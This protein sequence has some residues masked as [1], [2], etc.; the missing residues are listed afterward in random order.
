MFTNELL[1][2]VRKTTMCMT[3]TVLPMPNFQKEFKTECDVG[4]GELE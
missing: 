1:L 4:V 2:Y 3:P